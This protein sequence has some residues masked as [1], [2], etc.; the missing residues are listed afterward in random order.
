[1]YAEGEGVAQDY[2]EAVRWYRL[3]AEQGDAW[4]LLSLGGMYDQ[5]EGGSQ[6]YVLAYMWF[7]LAARHGSE[8]AIRALKFYETKLTPAQLAEAQRL[9]REWKAKG[10]E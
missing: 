7:T 4:A 9:A 5:G 1:M 8:S 6:N 10:K 3:A 2:Q